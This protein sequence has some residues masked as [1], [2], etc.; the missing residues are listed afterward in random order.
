MTV[1]Y[2]SIT[3][4]DPREFV[5]KNQFDVLGEMQMLTEYGSACFFTLTFSNVGHLALL[6]VVSA[7][8]PPAAG[9]L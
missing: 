7:N 9:R 3:P 1:V 5:F 4:L 8:L 6:V 2:Y